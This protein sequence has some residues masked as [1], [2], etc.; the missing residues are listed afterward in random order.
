MSGHRLCGKYR[1]VFSVSIFIAMCKSDPLTT[2]PTYILERR[3]LNCTCYSTSSGSS[4]L[5]W[6][7][8][9]TNST[10]RIQSVSRYMNGT[11]YVCLKQQS[12][13]NSTVDYTMQVAYG[14]G[15]NDVKVSGPSPFITDGSRQVNFTCEASNTYPKAAYAFLLSSNV[16]TMYCQSNPTPDTC[17]FTPKPEHNAL[18]VICTA[19]NTVSYPGEIIRADNVFI[20]DLLYPPQSLPLI[21]PEPVDGNALTQGD[22]IK[23]KVIGGHPLVSSVNFICDGP[24]LSDQTDVINNSSQSVESAITVDT[25]TA[26]A[27]A[28]VCNCSARWSPDSSIYAKT[29]TTSF[30]LQYPAS[31][32]NFT[33]SVNGITSLTTILESNH[34]SMTIRC[35]ATGRPLPSLTLSINNGQTALVSETNEEVVHF[36]RQARCENS[37]I[38]RCEADNGVWNRTSKEVIV[39]VLCEPRFHNGSF[40]PNVG[41]PEMTTD[42]LQVT[43]VANPRPTTFSYDYL[44]NGINGTSA[45]S[46][47]NTH[48][49]QDQTACGCHYTCKLIPVHVPEYLLGLYKLTASNGLGNYE[50]HFNVLRKV[51][52]DLST[53]TTFSQEGPSKSS[54][55]Q[56]LLSTSLS[57]NTTVADTTINPVSSTNSPTSQIKANNESSG[58]VLKIV[59]PV[60]AAVAVV[61]AVVVVI[62]KCRCPKNNSQTGQQSQTF[63]N[64]PRSMMQP[65]EHITSLTVQNGSGDSSIS[66]QENAELQ[67]GSVYVNASSRSPESTES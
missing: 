15:T 2:C 54:T 3:D 36:I 44:G 26:T 37:N 55:I 21:L 19:T 34:F 24:V 32:T 66:V 13:R 62:L 49:N 35:K 10:L 9:S 8:H 22:I 14:P 38:Y 40:D 65:P 57:Q 59:V 58:N 11:T 45:T 67:S 18:R 33:V 51:P 47:F 7:G 41:V 29:V 16:G 20:L 60:V 23:C 25:F 63:E 39:V 30:Q 42:G 1:L 53:T 17:V 43:L 5:S 46:N 4:G 27:N 61:V 6:L 31:I 50:L 56:I 52:L 28:M 48:C 64:N 12:G